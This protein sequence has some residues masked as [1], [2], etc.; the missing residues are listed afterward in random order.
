MT[1]QR[2]IQ[3]VQYIIRIQYNTYVNQIIHAS[4]VLTSLIKRA[5]KQGDSTPPCLTPAFNLNTSEKVKFQLTYVT[6]ILSQYSNTA[7]NV[8]GTCLRHINLTNSPWWFIRS[9]A[10]V[11][12]SAQRFT[13]QYI[14]ITNVTYTIDCM[15][16]SQKFFKP[17]LA[18]RYREY[19]KNH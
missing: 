1:E 9:E 15:R 2:V 6:Q 3:A 13:V 14:V 18:I 19:L 8:T 12:S 16:T 5:N 7:S 17:E 10:F 4:N 11:I